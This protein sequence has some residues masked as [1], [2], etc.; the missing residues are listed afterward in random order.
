[1]K[2][3]ASSAESSF[4]EKMLG[5]AKILED[6]KYEECFRKNAEL[7]QFAYVLHNED[8]MLLG[9]VLE[10][11]Y[12]NMAELVRTHKIPED[13]GAAI[14]EKLGRGLEDAVLAY[15]GGDELGKYRALRR[16]RAD[17]TIFQFTAFTTY[18]ER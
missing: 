7:T 17:A 6:G 10:S 2:G 15:G 9:E 11:I 14:S 12:L 4:A 8:W 1:M 16:M 3:E 5:I 13:V 18:P